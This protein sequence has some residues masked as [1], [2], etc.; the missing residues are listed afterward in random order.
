MFSLQGLEQLHKTIQAIQRYRN[1]NLKIKGILISRYNARS[2]LTRDLTEVINST[3]QAFN[4]KLFNTK[5][6]E[7][8]AVKE[9]QALQTNLYDYAPNSN[10]VKDYNNF[11]E[12]VLSND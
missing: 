11:I 8:I 10:A 9:A 5:I 2:I 6:R 12:E 7:C 3:A 1:P 4:T